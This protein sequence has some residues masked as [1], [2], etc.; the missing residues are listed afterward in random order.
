M[1][2]VEGFLLPR[3]K[4]EKRCERRQEEGSRHGLV[5]VCLPTCQLVGFSTFRLVGLLG[6]W[7][8]AAGVQEEER[9]AP[10]GGWL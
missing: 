10:G 6:S 5:V 7:R 2:T 3:G 4:T 8:D 9:R 1:C